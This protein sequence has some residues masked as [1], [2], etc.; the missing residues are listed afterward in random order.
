MT[1]EYKKILTDINTDIKLRIEWLK[2]ELFD[3]ESDLKT[4]IKLE[5]HNEERVV[6]AKIEMLI[7]EIDF[8][9][10]IQFTMNKKN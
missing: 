4:I 10:K 5:F 2:D 7:S 8:L 3:V 9:K 1:E 6:R